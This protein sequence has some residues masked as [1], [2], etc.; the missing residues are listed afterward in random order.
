ML[1]VECETCQGLLRFRIFE[2]NVE[3]V[4]AVEVVEVL[5]FAKFREHAN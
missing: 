5:D 4:E 2:V 1:Y 3:L